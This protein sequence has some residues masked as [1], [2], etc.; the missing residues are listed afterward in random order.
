MSLHDETNILVVDD[1]NTMRVQ[2]KELLKGF[3]FSN[4]N[5]VANGEVAK[6]EL[7][8]KSYQL[9]L[10]DWH[11]EPTNGI[12]LLKFVRSH[13]SLKGMAFIMVTAEC[14]KENVI[15]AVQAGVDDYLVKP[16]TRTQIETKV[17][18]TLLKKR[19]ST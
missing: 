10:C 3:G 11:M 9:V 12:E 4:I 1:V 15:L 19:Q 7:T 16:L 18:V 13:P 8:T 6:I 17:Y 5:A 2:V 14:T